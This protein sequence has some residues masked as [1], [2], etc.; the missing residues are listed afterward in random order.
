MANKKLKKISKELLKAS[1]MHKRQAE[2]TK[3]RESR[4]N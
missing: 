1:S 3:R 4:K 2:K